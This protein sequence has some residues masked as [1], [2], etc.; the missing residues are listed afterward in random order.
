MSDR[1]PNTA[2]PNY[3]MSIYT[4]NQ[5]NNS[6]SSPDELND[7]DILVKEVGEKPILNFTQFKPSDMEPTL[8][9]QSLNYT[10]YIT[11]EAQNALNIYDELIRRQNLFSLRA[12]IDADDIKRALADPNFTVKSSATNKPI[13]K[14]KVK[15]ALGMLQWALKNYGSNGTLAEVELGNAYWAWDG[16][17]ATDARGG[18]NKKPLKETMKVQNF[19][20]KYLFIQP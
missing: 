19:M 18:E 11:D 14:D 15:E 12:Y 7:S 10:R 20:K 3:D 13:P 6:A 9:A 17:F 8:I 4:K 5:K 2:P 16:S 1:I